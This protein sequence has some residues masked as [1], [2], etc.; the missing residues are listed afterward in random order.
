MVV[1]NSTGN[2]RGGGAEHLMT[3]RSGRHERR[4]VR[5]NVIPTVHPPSPPPSDRP[6][7]PSLTRT[8]TIG[9]RSRHCSR[10]PPCADRLSYRPAAT[11]GEP[12]ANPLSRRSSH[13]R[14][15]R[16]LTVRRHPRRVVDNHWARWRFGVWCGPWP[17]RSPSPL[18]GYRSGNYP[19]LWCSTDLATVSV[20]LNRVATDRCQCL[21]P[22]HPNPRQTVGA[23]TAAAC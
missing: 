9:E 16:S 12:C 4:A 1:F 8:A 15:N 14:S 20:T 17:Q 10:R 18:R 21:F 2:P 13:R 22:R 5:R 6:P 7:P 23:T 11:P 19:Q 3:L